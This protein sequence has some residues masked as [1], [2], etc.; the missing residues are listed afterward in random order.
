MMVKIQICS[1]FKRKWE[2]ENLTSFTSRVAK[3]QK[4][5]AF[6]RYVYFILKQRDFD[7]YT[8]RR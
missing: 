5:N 3:E 6:W 4:K 1:V 7:I 2:T 8:F